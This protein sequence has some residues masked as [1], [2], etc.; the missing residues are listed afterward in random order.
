MNESL[1]AEHL[2][3]WLLIQQFSKQVEG[4]EEANSI[5]NELWENYI[6]KNAELDVGCT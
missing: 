3:C 6:K 5:A 1:C 4:S 2:Q